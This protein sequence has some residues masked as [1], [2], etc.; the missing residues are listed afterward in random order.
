MIKNIFLINGIHVLYVAL[1]LCIIELCLYKYLIHVQEKE[2]IMDGINKLKKKLLKKIKDNNDDKSPDTGLNIGYDI[3]TENINKLNKYKDELLKDNIKDKS[4]VD[5]S[6]KLS[7]K[8]LSKIDE[9]VITEDITDEN[10]TAI[11]DKLI[12]TLKNIISDV[13]FK[14][15]Y[16]LSLIEDMIIKDDK[17]V[18]EHNINQDLKILA[19][20]FLLL[21]GIIILSK[22]LRNN[23]K[24]NRE[25]IIKYIVIFITVLVTLICIFGIIMLTYFYGQEYI[26]ITDK[27]VIYMTYKKLNIIK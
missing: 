13:K 11:I 19:I 15:D 26:Y 5:E 24:D 22:L 27:N 3:I 21:I 17:K 10:R 12:S 6:I 4:E 14:N 16:E 18:E 9:N 8:I 20:V 23:I 7:I 2:I 25:F 1:L